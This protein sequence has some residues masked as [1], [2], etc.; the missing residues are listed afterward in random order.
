MVT[1]TEQGQGGVGCWASRRGR[2]GYHLL[3]AKNIKTKLEV[4]KMCLQV[5]AALD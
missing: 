1:Y 5:E 4:K 3:Y 2:F